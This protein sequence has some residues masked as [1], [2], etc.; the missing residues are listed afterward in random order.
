M[1]MYR[2][3]SSS[4]HSSGDNFFDTL[5]SCVR[6]CVTEGKLKAVKLSPDVD[7]E[8][9]DGAYHHG[10][11]LSRWERDYLLLREGYPLLSLF[12]RYD[13]SGGPKE[14]GH[15]YVD[16]QSYGGVAHL[17]G[18]E[19]GLRSLSDM[20]GDLGARLAAELPAVD[21]KPKDPPKPGFKEGIWTIVIRVPGAEPEVFQGE[22]M[23][24]DGLDKAFDRLV[25][26]LVARTPK[27]PVTA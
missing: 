25:D 3:T 5:R 23:D 11:N 17:A 27:K 1:A 9:S 20:K 7:P 6:V 22:P 2:T 18:S 24:F 19:D 26:V 16:A 15:G 21:E 12:M 8:P 4:P 13:K 14:V 10:A